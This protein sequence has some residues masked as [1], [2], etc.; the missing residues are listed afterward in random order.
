M[1]RKQKIKIDLPSPA[2]RDLKKNNVK[3][4][5][6]GIMKKI[7]LL[8]DNP[9]LGEKMTSFK[10]WRRLKFSVRGVSYRVVYAFYKNELLVKII[11][12]APKGFAYKKAKRRK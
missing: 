2:K 6:E 11:S 10:Y 5:K 9:L 8:S 7:N 1:S 3:Y 4:N 12:I